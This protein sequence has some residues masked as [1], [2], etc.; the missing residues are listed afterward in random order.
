MSYYPELLAPAGNYEKMITALDFGADAVYLSGKKWGMRAFAGNFSDDELINAVKYCHNKGK[1]IYVTLN[2]IAH[3]SDFDGLLEYLNFLLEIKIDALIVSDMGII[4]FIKKN[5]PEI[6]LHISTQFSAT[7]YETINF[8]SNL[9]AERIVLPRELSFNE[10]KEIKTRTNTELEMFV[11]GAMC[12]GYSGRCMISY[13]LTGRDANQGACN[14]TC[15]F[16]YELTSSQLNEE[17]GLFVEEEPGRG[18]YFFNSKDLCL[19]EHLPELIDAEIDSFKIEG[20]MKTVSYLSQVVK[21]YRE[22]IDSYLKDKDN[23]V[24]RKEWLEDLHKISNRGY[25]TF[26][27]SDKKVKTDNTQEIR[28]SKVISTYEIAGIVKQVIK[29]KC[30]VV[31]V[32]QAFHPGDVLEIVIP[33]KRVITVSFSEIKD[34]LQNKLIRTNPNQIVLL[35]YFKSVTPGSMLRLKPADE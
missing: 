16:N 2:I 29:N 15:R 21:T 11:H 5:I 23:Y 18:S 19:L 33:G 4:S 10:I 9:G 26:K 1:K 25:T 30:L 24:F 20:R 27:F 28:T 32:K 17:Q 22:A 7:N 34:V 35:K 12:M 13:H 31:E 14:Q 6:P 3:N 8:L